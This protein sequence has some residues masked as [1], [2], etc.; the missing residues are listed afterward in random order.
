MQPCFTRGGERKTRFFQDLATAKAAAKK[1]ADEINQGE[2]IS[3][4]LTAAQRIEAQRAFEIS[5]TLKVPLDVIVSRY[6]EAHRQLIG[7]DTD[8]VEAARVFAK[9]HIGIVKKTLPEAVKELIEQIEAE[10]KNT[11][12]GTR[13]KV[14][15]LKLLKTHLVGKFAR[16]FNCQVA[17]LSS[18]ILEPWLVKLVCAERTRRNI[19]DC[20]AYFIKWAKARRY[21]PSDTDPLAH[22][23]NFRK[24]KV[25]AVEIISA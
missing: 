23:Q 1:I 18:A 16:D 24:R 20:V 12:N 25:G 10:Q 21:L 15:W 22:V 19:R 3:L 14:G 9:S 6:A 11:L 4:E 2:H 8:V 5:V 13:R 17:D 7:T